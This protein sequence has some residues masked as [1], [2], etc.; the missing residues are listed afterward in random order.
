MTYLKCNNCEW[1]GTDAELIECQEEGRYGDG[2]GFKVCP[3]C[4]TDWKLMDIEGAVFDI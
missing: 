1:K 2:Y 3:V 4:K